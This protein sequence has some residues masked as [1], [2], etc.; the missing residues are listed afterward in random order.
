MGTYKNFTAADIISSPSS[1]NQ[2]IDVIQEDVS[3]SLTRRKYQVF[4]T[5]GIGPG[6]T[7]SLFQTVYDQDFTLQTSNPVFDMTV[8][9]F[10]AGSTVTGAPGYQQSSSGKLLF[11]SQSVM[12]REKVD[13]YKQFASFLLGNSDSAFYLGASSYPDNSGVATSV[14]DRIDNALFINFKRLFARDRLRK[15]TFAMRFYTSASISGRDNLT[16]KRTATGL[17]DI[18]KLNK[19]YYVG[20]LTN[21]TGSNVGHPSEEGVE[22]FA[23]VGA[24]TDHRSTPGGSVA[25]LKKASN[26]NTDV[27]LLFY[28]Y[29]IGVFD[30]AKICYKDQ[31]MS[32]TID[33]MNATAYTHNTLSVLAGKQLI[34][35]PRADSNVSGSFIP[36]FLVS[37]S[38]DNIIDHIAGTRFSSGTLTSMAFQNQTNIQS[39][40]YFC[41]ASPGEF[42]YSTNPTFVDAAGSLNVIED[43]TDPTERSFTFITTVGLY[44][45]QNELVA[46][47]KISRPIEKNDEKDLNVRVRLDF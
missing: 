3:G 32:G 21:R 42:N 18:T 26:T 28:D 36:D 34:G 8:G 14:T 6:I 24:N 38:I 43:A 33:A 16:S 11:A 37:A 41:R 22:I 15:E 9:L 27:G 5:G 31:H 35:V 47:G 40:I 20:G 17:V 10:D 39:S 29:G 7:S 2:L 12:M 25:R 45:A 13:N 30:L 23:D 4:V 46:V 44:N 19:N 1:L